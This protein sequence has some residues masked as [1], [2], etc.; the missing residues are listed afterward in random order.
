ME[1]YQQ[2]LKADQ[3]I[4][5]SR[6]QRPLSRAY[7]SLDLMASNELIADEKQIASKDYERT[8]SEKA[9]SKPEFFKTKVRESIIDTQRFKSAVVDDELKKVNAE[10]DIPA[11][12]QKAYYDM[13]QAGIK[14]RLC[15]DK[16]YQKLKGTKRF[17]YLDQL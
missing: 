15:S 9:K 14:A 7:Q 11:E 5:A 2:T 3:A 13:L 17:E 12:L 1:R 8:K 10:T 4:L 16:D 6:V